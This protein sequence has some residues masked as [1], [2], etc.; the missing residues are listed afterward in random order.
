MSQQISDLK[1]ESVKFIKQMQSRYGLSLLDRTYGNIDEFTATI[2]AGLI[3]SNVTAEDFKS[4]RE[5]L[6]TGLKPFV[7]YPPTLESLIQLS[8]LVKMFPITESIINLKDVWYR[9]DTEYSQK[10]GRFW[11]GE[12]NYDQLSR[13][14]V[15]LH[16]FSE[17]QASPS[18]V[19]KVMSRIV[20]STIFR[21]YPPALD[22]FMDALSAVRYP[23]A[24]LVEE[25]WL[26]ALSTQPGSPVHPL[27]KKT[28][29]IVGAYDLRVNSNQRSI[30]TQFKKI[31]RDLLEK[32][33]CEEITV[34]VEAVSAEYMSKEALIKMLG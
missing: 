14:R 17:K 16:A 15:W 33:E 23:D 2:V 18:E 27:I 11:R 1:S 13:E 26:L 34:K 8:N 6:L 5:W 28:R 19:K 22:Q 4:V 9:L 32:Q 25:A 21:Q 31:Y 24:P 10:Y 7:E 30:E 12:S 3:R 20:E 29:G